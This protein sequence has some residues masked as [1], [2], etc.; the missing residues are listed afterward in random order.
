M[1][2]RLEDVALTIH[3]HPTMSEAYHQAALAGLGHPLHI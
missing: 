1:S 3:A 2:A